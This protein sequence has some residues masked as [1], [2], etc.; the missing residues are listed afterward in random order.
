MDVL[1]PWASGGVSDFSHRLTHGHSPK[2]EALC[3]RSCRCPSH[4]MI[5]PTPWPHLFRA[6]N[7]GELGAVLQ[8][9][10]DHA[11]VNDQLREYWDKPLGVMPVGW[12]SLVHD[13]RGTGPTG[14]A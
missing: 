5:F 2:R 1:R 6:V 10:A 14:K 8:T 12:S 13:G 11:L 9:F 7:A 4:N 3:E